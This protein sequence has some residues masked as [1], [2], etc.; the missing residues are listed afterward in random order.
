M[1][2]SDLTI[3][4]LFTVKIAVIAFYILSLTVAKDFVW[5]LLLSSYVLLLL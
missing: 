4:V 2:E 3:V 5:L 1:K